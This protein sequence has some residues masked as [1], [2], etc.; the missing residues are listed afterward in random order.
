MNIFKQL[1][2]I[3]NYIENNLEN[4]IDYRK[5]SKIAC[6]SPYVLQRLFFLIANISLFEYI[7]R[8]RLSK[9]AVDIIN[10]E[11]VID[12]A[13]KYQYNS[14]EAFSRAFKTMHGVNP[15][16][17][18]K[19]SVNL[20]LT[21]ILT[22]NEN[23]NNDLNINYKIVKDKEFNLYTHSFKASEEKL[24]DSTTS[25]WKEMKQKYNF[26]SNC[27]KRYG[28]IEYKKEEI[29]YHVGLEDNNIDGDKLTIPKSKFLVVSFNSF[30]A[31]DIIT[32]A[33][34]IYENYPKFLGCEIKYFFDIEVYYKDHVELWFSI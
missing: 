34:N 17:L 1:N 32:K 8:R 5:L 16:I 4:N 13:L 10:G 28:V 29:I 33:N 25:F 2:E 11:K 22:F 24:G 9:A 26:F 12:V 30:K 6:T 15:S 18:K 3:V 20:N 31:K 21:P 14:S 7:K 27:E 23:N 19:K